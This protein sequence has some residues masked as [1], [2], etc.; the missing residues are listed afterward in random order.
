MS[1][2]SSKQECLT[3]F[4][5]GSCPLCRREIALYQGLKSDQAIAWMDVS[6]EQTE[7]PAN[8]QRDTLMQRFHIQSPDGE[9]QSGALAFA[10]LWQA[11]PGW[12]W[13]GRLAKLPGVLGWM[14]W[15]YLGFLKIRPRM[16]HA[17][18]WW[19]ADAVPA[20][21]VADLRSDQAGET[22]AVWI[23][24][25]VLAVARNPELRAFAQQHLLTEQTHLQ[26]IN[27]VLPVLR[28]SKLLPVWRLAGFLTGALPALFG[29]RSVYFTIAAVETFVDQHYA[30]QIK[31][32][33]TLCSHPG[34]LAQLQ[35]HQT[36]ECHHR[37][38]ATSLVGAQPPN[39]LQRLWCKAIGVGSA[40]GVALARKI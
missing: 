15:L 13:L 24:K 35:S 8:C 10:T 26:G 16:Q 31:K 2:P 25:G 23:Y 1:K 14:E 30:E 7:L 9:L 19:A 5:D 6:A 4:Y 32:L 29:A 28:R 21:M 39:A 12:R 27:G 33:Q 34:L 18:A 38:E 40:V 3:V 20:A 22:G 17:M 11:L 36:D 37:D